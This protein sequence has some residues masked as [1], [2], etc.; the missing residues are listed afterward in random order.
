MAS[1]RLRT[2]SSHDYIWKNHRGIL[3]GFDGSQRGGKYTKHFQ[4]YISKIPS[5][6]R[7]FYCNDTPSELRVMIM[8]QL[9][10]T[11][12]QRLALFHPQIETRGKHSVVSITRSNYLRYMAIR[13]MKNEKNVRNSFSI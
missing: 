8:I 2:E 11:V 13:E 3:K 10:S 1:D 7:K 4:G 9:Q 12:F 5:F 6:D